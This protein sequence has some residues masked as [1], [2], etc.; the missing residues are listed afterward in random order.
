MQEIMVNCPDP[1]GWSQ[2]QIDQLACIDPAIHSI[3]GEPPPFNGRFRA[4]IFV[5]PDENTEI[6]AK[7]NAEVLKRRIISAFSEAE[8]IQPGD[9]S[10]LIIHLAGTVL[11]IL[12]AIFLEISRIEP[13][14]KFGGWFLLAILFGILSASLQRRRASL[15]RKGSDVWCKVT[16][17]PREAANGTSKVVEFDRQFACDTCSGSGARPGS[18]AEKCPRCRGRGKND[19]ISG[20]SYLRTLCPS[21]RGSGR[22]IREVCP[23]CQG[24]R[25]VPRH[26]SRKVEIPPNVSM[27]CLSGDGEPST[28][29]GPPGDCYCEICVKGI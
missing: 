27:L 14:V 2:Q 15:V 29:G 11:L 23:S 9:T 12:I 6:V 22:V 26:V 10:R 1:I 8:T 4:A 13:A 18:R 20:V 17:E 21:C 25:Y 24:Q 16:L 7:I 28:S 5:V 19:H 3:R